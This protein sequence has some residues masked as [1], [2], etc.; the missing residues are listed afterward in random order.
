MDKGDVYLFQYFDNSYLQYEGEKDKD[1]YLF[2]SLENLTDY[3]VSREAFEEMTNNGNGVF[4]FKRIFP[5]LSVSEMIKAYNQFS[6]QKNIE[7]EDKYNNF[8]ELF[9]DFEKQNRGFFQLIEDCKNAGS[10]VYSDT[11]IEFVLNKRYSYDPSTYYK[12]FPLL[13]EKIIDEMVLSLLPDDDTAVFILSKQQDAAYTLIKSKLSQLHYE[14]AMQIIDVHSGSFSDEELSLI[15]KSFSGIDKDDTRKCEILINIRDR[16]EHYDFI[17]KTTE[18]I[19]NDGDH[20][21]IEEY[22]G[23]RIYDSISEPGSHIV[24]HPD[25]TMFIVGMDDSKRTGKREFITTSLK[26]AHEYI[27]WTANTKYSNNKPLNSNFMENQKDYQKI[28]NETEYAG[29]AWK[30]NSKDEK[31]GDYFNV[32]V[33]VKA[34]QK[35]CETVSGQKF[36]SHQQLVDYIKG[37]ENGDSRV[38]L[39]LQAR[40]N[41]D[42]KTKSTHNLYFSKYHYSGIKDQYNEINFSIDMKKAIDFTDTYNQI[43]VTVSPKTQKENDK[44]LLRSDYTVYFSAPKPELVPESARNMVKEDYTKGI[45]GNGWN[46]NDQREEKVKV[47]R[48][49]IGAV[50]SNT[51]KEKEGKEVRE[52][53]ALS[54]NKTK[55]LEAAKGKDSVYVT[56]INH[57]GKLMPCV[58][59]KEDPKA[60]YVLKIA[61]H[62]IEDSEADKKGN[63]RWFIFEKPEEKIDKNT[64]NASHLYVIPKSLVKA[65]ESQDEVKEL[66]KDH[67]K[68]YTYSSGWSKKQGFFWKDAAK[69]EKKESAPKKEAPKKAADAKS[70][71][72]TSKGKEASKPAKKGKGINM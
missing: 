7:F 39:S 22:K 23:H 15:K 67:K 12:T 16:A 18:K 10:Q 64:L 37:M 42:E 49:F 20:K 33:D 13:S 14:K 35:Y 58:S 40:K 5:D 47:D 55:L 43:S 31:K 30:H 52:Y 27:D 53:L 69:G 19:I 72:G 60:E 11:V 70:S 59:Q 3:P 6:D 26:N 1:F 61:K 34:L 54:T 57:E 17:K 66:P 32:N 45:F 50:F 68:E 28:F 24:V 8:H 56:I 48:K 25:H 51:T 71:K 44:S 41:P 62:E 2:R 65:S 36:N 4:T 21:F 46:M 9:P 29:R 38:Y 63:I